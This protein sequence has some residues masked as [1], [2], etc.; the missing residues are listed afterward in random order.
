MDR[1]LATQWGVPD[2]EPAAAALMYC[3]LP[4]CTIHCRATINGGRGQPTT[5]P[6]ATV[7]HSTMHRT[8]QELF[9]DPQ[10]TCK[11]TCRAASSS[12]V[13][14]QDQ[15]QLLE[16]LWG[17]HGGQGLI[18]ASGGVDDLLQAA[19]GLHIGKAGGLVLAGCK[20]RKKCTAA[21]QLACLSAARVLLHQYCC[22]FNSRLKLDLQTASCCMRDTK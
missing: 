4:D 16:A 15:V 5:R 19:L 14:D 20:E 22:F 6:T 13:V 7:L 17:N 18:S 8:S 1:R 21:V 2:S 3:C 9:R 10:H 12:G 11:G